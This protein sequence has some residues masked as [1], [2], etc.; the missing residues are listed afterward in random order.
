[1][2]LG[3]LTRPELILSDLT[4]TDP[5][6]VDTILRAF[7]DRIAQAG[8]VK[9]AGE[10]FRRL[11]EREQLSSTGIGS[12]IAIPHCKMPV[13]KQA[14]VAVGLAPQGIDFG[15]PDGQPVRLFFLVVSP[16]A[17]PAEHLRVLASISR[18]V[19]TGH[20]AERLLESRDP[21]EVQRF[22]EEEGA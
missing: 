20:N 15:A 10:L 4:A 8:V 21:Q 19:K 18:W 14:V 17:S 16:E 13:L 7:A 6:P 5:T 3:S 11:R 22:L 12:G 1:M 2:G 9:D